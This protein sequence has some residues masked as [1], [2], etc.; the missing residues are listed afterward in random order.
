MWLQISMKLKPPKK[1]RLEQPGSSCGLPKRNICVCRIFLNQFPLF[2]ADSYAHVVLIFFFH[3]E[4]EKHGWH[5]PHRKIDLLTSYDTGSKVTCAP[6]LSLFE[7]TAIIDPRHL[8]ISERAAAFSAIQFSACAFWRVSVGSFSDPEKFLVNE[9]H[10][11]F[12]ALARR[13]RRDHLNAPSQK[14]QLADV[15]IVQGFHTMQ[16]C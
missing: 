1:G 12:E 8:K 5:H 13:S 11:H 10:F 7:T 3:A 16:A 15:C 4:E 2:M 6:K 9:P 14:V